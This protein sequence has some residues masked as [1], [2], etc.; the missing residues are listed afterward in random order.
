M[1]PIRV[2]D[3][4]LLE[5]LEDSRLELYNLRNDLQE[6]KN[7]AAEQAEKT[8]E[9]RNCLAHRRTGIHAQMPTPNPNFRSKR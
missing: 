5:Y 9:L 4:K 6:N 2:G 8:S 7:V 3:W 1:S